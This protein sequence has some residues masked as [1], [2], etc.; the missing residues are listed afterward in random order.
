[1]LPRYLVVVARAWWF[2]LVMGVVLGT[3]TTTWAV[4]DALKRIEPL[5]CVQP[6]VPDST[7]L[8]EIGEE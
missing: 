7:A 4:T 1:M 5:I 8:P 2:P 6:I 3:M